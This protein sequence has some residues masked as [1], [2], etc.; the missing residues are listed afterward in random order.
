MTKGFS[1]AL[2]FVVI[3][4]ANVVLVQAQRG[5]SRPG[6]L[7]GSITDRLTGQPIAKAQISIES[8]DQSLSAAN[9]SQVN[10]G[11]DGMYRVE[12]ASG[13]YT[14][15]ISATGYTTLL[16][17]QVSITNDRTVIEDVPLEAAI[18]ESVN[19]RS[20]VFAADPSLP[21]SSVTLNRAEIRATP[22]TGGDPLR[23]INSLPG[24]TS[25]STEFA[26]LIVRGGATGENLTFIENIPVDDFTY[27]TDKYDNGRGGRIAILPPDVFDRLEFSA[28]GFGVRYGDKLSSA[29]DIK[30]RTAARDRV[31]GT[32]Y[33][34]SGS[35]GITVETPLGRRGGWLFSA[36]RSY[37]DIAFDIINLGQ[38]GRPRDFDFI[39]KFDFDL[40]PHHKL[41]ITA[42]N[43][44]ERFTLSR[45]QAFS[46]DRRVDQL[47]TMRSG[48]RAIIG[49]TLN[50]TLGTKTL[51]RITL[52]GSG[53]HNDGTF[54]RLDFNRTLQRARDLRDSQFGVKEELTAA[55]TPRLLVAAG[56]GVVA[57]QA[58][59]FTFEQ[60][61][62][63]FSPLE[64][65]F[66][67]P[68]HSNRMKLSTTT[69]IY[70]YGQVTWRPTGRLSVTPGLRV[71]R[72]GLTNQTLISP[73]ASA[74]VN[75]AS[76][77]SLNFAAGVYRQPPSLFVLSLA[78]Q[79]RSLKAERAVHVI[80]G[81][82]WLIGED[83]RV[84]AEAYQKSYGNLIL[85]PSL[86]SPIYTGIGEGEV[87]GVDVVAQKTLGGRFGGEAVYSY[88]RSRRRFTLG[89]FSFPADTERPHQL[90]LIGM[91]RLV[92]FGLAAKYRVATGLPYT[93]RI[94][95]EIF[96]GVFLQRIARPEDRNSARLPA[97]ANLDLRVERRFNFKRFSLAPYVDL[98]NITGH[99]SN[100]EL[101][102][103]FFSP[104]PFQ[105]VEGKL[106][107]IFGGRIEF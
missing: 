50:S 62:F 25:A 85:R 57:Q 63:G 64:E 70:G 69:T 51:S 23:V 81:V 78:P 18:S 89:D 98:F 94:P 74:R 92:G 84:T 48:R 87:R 86:G 24:V 19:V 73:R 82:E 9:Q 35:A 77:F 76:R 14:L 47:E 90:T 4:C 5:Q 65:E 39:N 75:L 21:V 31:Q 95:V 17:S 61:P 59:Y 11:A 44:F 3:L 105:L 46:V 8:Q 22:G 26:D 30:L 83:L 101:D 6:V 16:V 88:T 54:R 79:N 66:F 91:T 93:L 15:R 71:E 104:T 38:F 49:L 37:I 32:L 99:A 1:R 2:L 29:L 80:A 33:A 41:T 53:A 100:T 20:E 103:R 72:F 28:G 67:A 55:P 43:L 106:L 97:F 12:L 27:G 56:G 45:D 68:A 96:P 60:S 13:T 7:T 58:N 42:L 40:A 107:P 52:W 102:Y 36:R 34:D 10:T